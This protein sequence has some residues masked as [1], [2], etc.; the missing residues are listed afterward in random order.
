MLLRVHKSLALSFVWFS[1]LLLPSQK[2]SNK[3]IILIFLSVTL[4]QRF[5]LA[6]K[7]TNRNKSDDHF[8]SVHNTSPICH[9]SCP[10]RF[11]FSHAACCSRFRK[12]N[13]TFCVWLWFKNK[14]HH[15]TVKS[16]AWRSNAWMKMCVSCSV[17]GR[18]TALSLGVGTATLSRRRTDNSPRVWATDLDHLQYRL[19]ASW[20]YF[21]SCRCEHVSFFDL[22][23]PPIRAV[24]MGAVAPV[25]LHFA[26]VPCSSS[27]V[28]WCVVAATIMM[29]F[30]SSFKA[31][32]L[33]CSYNGFV[34]K[35]SSPSTNTL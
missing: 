10:T 22:P 24:L 30:P 16:K 12:V 6:G 26:M 27:P 2:R 7:T 31:N 4:A 29:F 28:S 23:N 11:P 18:Q 1:A 34:V 25:A 15:T 13:P 5:S 32:L 35:L 33:A 9:K 3:Q 17:A 14:I 21:R 19:A 20:L 8:V